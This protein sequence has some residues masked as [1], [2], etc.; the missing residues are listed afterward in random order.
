MNDA[1]FD[2]EPSDSLQLPGPQIPNAQIN[3]QAFLRILS[4]DSAM[5][6]SARV[7]FFMGLGLDDEE[8]VAWL[9]PERVPLGMV[10][11]LEGEGDTGKSL[12]VADMAARVTTGAPW[13]GRVP[14]PN[15]AG[16]VLFCV[17]EDG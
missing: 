13:P 6:E 8:A 17:E 15:P 5:Y 14:G 9:W 1:E 11:V 16:E 3:E 2:A 4:G 7:E 12:I 10:T